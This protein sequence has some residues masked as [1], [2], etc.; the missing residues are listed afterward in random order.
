LFARPLHPYTK[1]LMAA[2]TSIPRKGELLETIPGMA[3]NPADLPPACR[4]APRCQAR[5]DYGLEICQLHAPALKP[6]GEDRL[7]RCWLYHGH[8]S[9]R[10]PMSE[11]LSGSAGEGAQSAVSRA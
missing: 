9:H 2:I 8:G 4:F 1:G 7:V 10:P 11:S 5:L 3:P 6:A